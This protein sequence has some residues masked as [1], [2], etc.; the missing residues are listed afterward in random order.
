MQ[1]HGKLQ[2]QE[3]ISLIATLEEV[4]DPGVDRSKDHDLV[5][6]LVI[7]AHLDTAPRIEVIVF[8]LR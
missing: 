8:L 2:R 6:L 5:D 4:P 3:I 1:K 7:G